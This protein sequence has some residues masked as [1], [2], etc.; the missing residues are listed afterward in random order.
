MNASEVAVCALLALTLMFAVGC[1]N[2]ALRVNAEIARA[3]LEIQSTSGPLIR[4]AR[5]NAA[6]ASAQAVHDSGGNEQAARA[7]A[8]ET[9][10]NWQCTLDGHGFY[11]A[12][13][14]AYID[15]IALWNTGQDFQWIDVI[16]YV[17]RAIDSYVVLAS[18]LTSLG[19]DAL[20]GSASFI[21]QISAVLDDPSSLFDLT[22]STWMTSNAD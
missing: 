20:T 3:M 12:A 13:V 17:R 14:S 6:I 18:C 2:E 4:E 9:A 22:P 8:I 1:G 19:N 21:N 5:V 11:A 10:S 15:T 16:P 7:A